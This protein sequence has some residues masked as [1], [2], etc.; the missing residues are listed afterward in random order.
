MNPTRSL[1]NSGL[2][3]TALGL[4]CATLAFDETEDALHLAKE[5]LANALATG[6]T[7]FD[8]APFYGQGLSERIVG[9]A[10]RGSDVV[11]SSKVGRLLVPDKEASTYIPF[12]VEYDYTYDGIMRSVEDSLQRLG[13]SDIDIL[14]AHD[15]GEH[16]HGKNAPVRL[17]EFFDG[18]GYQA[19]DSLRSDGTVKAIGLGVNEVAV[20]EQVMERGFFDVFLLA[21]RHTLL[22]RTG[23]LSFFGQCEKAGT[24]IVIG[25]PFNSGL[26]VGGATYNYRAVPVDIASRHKKLLAFCTAHDVNIGAAALQ[27]PLRQNVVKSVIP[28]PKTP[29]ELCQIQDWMTHDIPASFWN[30]LG[31]LDETGD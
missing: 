31:N 22:E 25:G 18:G 7:F 1:T 15:L 19:L 8:T 9:D 20:C 29:T 30:D 5:M 28:G 26:L 12:R 13:R 21:G 11:L 16:T 10:L 4:G 3:I 17:T 2:E 14:Y 23:S 24:D 27:F 6:I